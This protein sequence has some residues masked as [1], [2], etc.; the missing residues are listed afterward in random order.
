MNKDFLMELL[1]SNGVSGSEA[2]IEKKIYDHMMP[3]ADVVSVDEMGTVTAVVN[4]QA[5]FR[6]LMTGHAD[7]IGL[8]V[9]AVTSDGFL[10]VTNIG[11]VYATT[12][13]GHKVRIHTGRGIIYG[14]VVNTRELCKK[15]GL[16]ASDL[17]ID[18]GAVDREDAL[19]A[20]SLGDTVN[21]DTDVRE[22]LN[23]RITGRAMDD[24]VGAY[25]VMEALTLAK[26]RG[27]SVGVYAAATTGEETTGNGAYF[28]ASRVHPNI[29]IAVDVTYTSDYAGIDVGLTG[30]ISV[31]KG[32]V[33]CNNPSIH[34]KV[35]EKLLEAAAKQ[36]M[37]VQIEAANGHTGT[38]GD[39]M[40]RTCLG[41]PFALV[42]IPLRYMH[43]PDEVGSLK[44]IQDCA[45]LLAQF[46]CDCSENMDLKPF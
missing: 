19:K 6:V 41:V 20:V 22:L 24:R 32:P 26:E 38:D 5:P 1:C 44:D 9:T 37:A 10:K 23:G 43:C 39:I 4:P 35:N 29:A 12:Y 18:I 34:K 40:H 13:P 33:I 45:E 14:A 25:I 15:E 46:L 30:D 17:T 21:F 42:S 3:I 27:A 16:K 11:G 31:G 36:N 8:M 7:E 28:T 2:E